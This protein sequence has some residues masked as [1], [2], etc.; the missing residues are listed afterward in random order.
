MN[1]F[2]RWRG[3]S[4][5]P[6]CGEH[7]VT[8]RLILVTNNVLTIKYFSRAL[9][10]DRAL[11][12]RPGQLHESP[13]LLKWRHCIQFSVWFSYSEI[14][15]TQIFRQIGLRDFNI[16]TVANRWSARKF[17]W[18]AEKFEYYLQFHVINLPA[19][20]SCIIVMY[21]RFADKRNKRVITIAFFHHYREL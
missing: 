2:S 4:F 20:A 15:F 8:C 1:P 21:K 10:W 19:S 7:L 12:T 9:T 14:V 3:F 17:C 16:S 13:L 11:N 6:D 18:S 5:F